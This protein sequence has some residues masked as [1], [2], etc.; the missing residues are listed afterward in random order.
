MCRVAWVGI[1][2]AVVCVPACKRKEAPPPV[3]SVGLESQEAPPPPPPPAR[4][5]RC[6]APK[7]AA[8]FAIRGRAKASTDAEAGIDLPYAVEVGTAAPTAAGFA[9]G[10]L[11][12]DEGAPHALVALSDLSGT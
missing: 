1:A 10:A 5:A 2:L 6:V 3:G 4:P 11:R 7:D 12:Y 8:S 9:L